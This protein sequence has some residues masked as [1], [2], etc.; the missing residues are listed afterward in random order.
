M[1]YTSSHLNYSELEISS[2]KK[3]LLRLIEP[4]LEHAKESLS[5]TSDPEVTRYMGA[6]FS[7]PTL[8]KETKRIQEIRRNEDEY[9]WMIELNGK[10]IGNVSIKSIKEKTASFRTKAGNFT[11]L[12]GD[13]KMWSRGIGKVVTDAIIK[14]AFNKAGF[15]ILCARALQE[16]NM[17]I[18]LLVS[19]GFQQKERTLYDGLVNGRKTWWC[20][21]VLFPGRSISPLAL[22]DLDEVKRIDDIVF[23]HDAEDREVYED[24]LKTFPEGCY[25]IMVGEKMAGFL[26]SEAWSDYHTTEIN[27]KASVFHNPKGEI[28]FV[29]ALGILPEFQGKGLGGELLLFFIEKMKSEGR[30]SIYLMAANK[31]RTFYEKYGFRFVKKEEDRGNIYDVLEFPFTRWSSKIKKEESLRLSQN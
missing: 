18:K 2:Y 23:P 1:T 6:D 21:F 22:A 5:W 11:I 31:A 12:I 15:K 19:A 30:K 3:G 16:N 25:K 4:K 26:T 9:N 7:E 24:R 17:S 13:K 28:I 10:I 8:E 29:S 14:W 27:R 20:N